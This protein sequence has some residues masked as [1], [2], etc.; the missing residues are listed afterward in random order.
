MIG[1]AGI[2]N[3]NSHTKSAD[4]LL[5]AIADTMAYATS[6]DYWIGGEPWIVLS[7]E[8][9]HVLSGAGLSKPDVRREL[10][11]RSK[12]RGARMTA[13]DLARTRR[14]REVELGTVD[15]QTLLPISPTPELIG[16][17]V[18]GAAGTHSIYVP[19]FGITR[20]VTLAVTPTYAS[21][22]L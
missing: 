10:W 6:N 20:S 5:R 18:A 12:M 2:V 4:D 8:H 1:A 11:Q 22:E 17:V 13:S 14:V 3:M 19:S 7:P 9:A 21:S 16:I 15:E